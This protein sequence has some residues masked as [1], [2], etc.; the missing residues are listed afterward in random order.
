MG[1]VL[2]EM[3]IWNEPLCLLSWEETVQG[4]ESGM[5]PPAGRLRSLGA[6]DHG[7]GE[8]WS[9]SR[10]IWKGLADGLGVG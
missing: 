8:R 3:R 2:S 4:S 9:D 7:S 6:R 10:D 5:R 1:H